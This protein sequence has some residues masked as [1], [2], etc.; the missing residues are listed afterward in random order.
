M[1]EMIRVQYKL[2]DD[3]WQL[4][5]K[6]LNKYKHPYRHFQCWIGLAV[7]VLGIAV[8]IFS[9]HT[10]RI[11][12]LALI[13]IGVIETVE[14]FLRKWK[15]MKDFQQHPSR[16]G[17]IAAEFRDESFWIKSPNSESEMKYSAV[18]EVLM[19]PMGLLIFV[20]KRLPLVIPSEAFHSADEMMEVARRFD[21]SNVK[22][23][24]IESGR[25]G[26]TDN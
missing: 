3:C 12:P 17:D 10:Y 6:A 1:R 23:K 4:S 9:F 19:T 11:V 18:H 22:T 21:K 15:F 13:V 14:P 7:L 25:R 8:A 24:I 2:T 5:H 16:N 26:L 20:Q